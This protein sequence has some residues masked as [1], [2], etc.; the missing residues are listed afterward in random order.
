[1]AQAAADQTWRRRPLWIAKIRGPIVI[2][3]NKCAED[4][5]APRQRKE[6]DEDEENEKEAKDGEGKRGCVLRWPDKAMCSSEVCRA[7]TRAAALARAAAANTK[8]AED[9]SASLEGSKQDKEDKA[10]A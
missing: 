7:R 10:A 6:E 8:C 1:M 2:E 3:D 4:K 5:G 9:S